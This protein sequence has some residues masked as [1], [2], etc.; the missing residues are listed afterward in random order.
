MLD[1]TKLRLTFKFFNLKPSLNP[2]FH[3]TAKTSLQIQLHPKPKL[4]SKS[5]I[6]EAQAALLDYLHSTR[7]LQFLDADNMCKNSPFFIQTLVEKTLKNEKLVNPKRLISRYLRYHP[8][9]EFE[10]FFESLGLKPSEYVPLLPRDLIFLNDDPVMMENYHTLCNYGVPRSKMGKIFK[11]APEVFRFEN[12]VLGLKIKAYEKMGVSSSVLVN[13]V[14][15]SPG[16]LVGDVNVDFVEVVDMLKDI[17]ADG[18][19]VDSGWI[20]WDFLDEVYCNWGLMRELLCLLSDAGLRKE[21]LA[22]IIQRS[23]CVVFEE[24]GGRTLSM[25]GFLTKFGLSVNQIAPVFLEFP[26]IRMVKFLANLR[27]CFQLLTEIEMEAAEIGKI[28]QSHTLFIGSYTLK[29][30]KSLLGCLNVGKKRLCA[31]V[32]ENPHE[33]KKWILGRRVKPLVSLREEEEE[34]SKAG[35]T[36]FLLRLGYVENSKQ[37]N[38]AFKVFRGKGAELQERFDFI[39]NAGLTRDEVCRMIR[40]SPQILNQNTD[41]VKMKIEYLKK[42]GYSVS[43]LVSFPSY[44]SYKSL[45]VK[46]RLSMYNWLIDNGA[47]EPGLALSTIIACTDR[48]FLQS[49]VNRHPSGLQV[50]EDLQKEIHSED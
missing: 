46:H 44:L 8:I 38:T 49:Y 24:S 25:I 35:K 41:R 45:R 40:V 33:M 20:K 32:Q 50:W 47:V 27:V 16:I 37:M 39:V 18:G 30:T 1:I 31:I 5:T 11:Q 7:S 29:T 12:G 14:A 2:R 21:E 26:Q 22:E 15:V 28:F 17:V 19:D 42:K 13:A 3:S 34:R 9:N 48:I 4:P 36:E 23:P 10:P 43:D 6:K